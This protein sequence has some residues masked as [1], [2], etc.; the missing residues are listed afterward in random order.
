M[1]AA[2]DAIQVLC[3]LKWQFTWHKD[4][5][6]T[7]STFGDTSAAALTKPTTLSHPPLLGINFGAEIKNKQIYFDSYD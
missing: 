5:D 7:A 4:F 1:N 6:S 2:R 3:G